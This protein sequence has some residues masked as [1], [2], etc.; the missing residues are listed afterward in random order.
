MPLSPPRI[1]IVEDHR[2]TRELLHLVLGLEGYGVI[3]AGGVS[4]ALDIALGGDLDLIIL[5][6]WLV[7]GS[8]VMLCRQI[9]CFNAAT[10]ILFYSSAGYESDIRKA[11][12]AGAQGYVVK[13]AGP[14][15]LLQE[16]RRVI[17]QPGKDEAE[18]KSNP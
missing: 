13:P 3:S 14:D 15:R 11:V 18:S 10:P 9:R 5:D 7:E 8:G 1:L 4:E 12:G 17:G 2:D 6:T 16:I